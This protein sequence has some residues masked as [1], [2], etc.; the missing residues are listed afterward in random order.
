MNDIFTQY[1]NL[2]CT[3]RSYVVQSP[4]GSYTIMINSRMSH[5]MQLAAYDHEFRHIQNRDFEKNCSVDMI[6]YNAHYRNESKCNTI[7]M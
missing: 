7:T 2:P 3:I 6:E 5:E 1:S 4:D